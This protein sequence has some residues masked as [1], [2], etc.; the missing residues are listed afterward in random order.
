[1][2]YSFKKSCFWYRHLLNAKKVNVIQLIFKWVWTTCI[3]NRHHISYLHWLTLKTFFFF[4]FTSNFFYSN[5]SNSYQPHPCLASC[6]SL[7][8]YHFVHTQPTCLTLC[9]VQEYRWLLWKQPLSELWQRHW[10]KNIQPMF[11]MFFSLTLFILS[12]SYSC[13]SKHHPFV[14]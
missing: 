5:S 7:W 3:S 12:P 11:Y 14:L 4:S 9:S 1:M 8:L 13:K 2:I 10:W 6:L